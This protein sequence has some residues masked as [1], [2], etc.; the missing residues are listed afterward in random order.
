MALRD[1]LRKDIA[2]REHIEEESKKLI[3]RWKRELKNLPPEG[4][5][6]HHYP[7]PRAGIDFA[8]GRPTIRDLRLSGVTFVCRY[9]GGSTDKDLTPDEAE[10]YSGNEIDIVTIWESA[11][12]RAREGYDAG[13]SDA[14]AALRQLGKCRAPEHAVVYFAVDFD[15]SAGETDEYFRGAKD[16][17]GL[18][19]VG[20]YG[21][22]RVVSHLIANRIVRYGWQTYAWSGG[23]WSPHAQL[24]QVQNGV[25]LGGVAVDRDEA[26]AA[27]FGQWR[28]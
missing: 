14:R 12:Q 25:W 26:V 4:P 1:I 2:R 20:V 18:S 27:D 11:A 21:G 19:R 8:W 24:R 28:V 15:A 16:V 6:M 22:I 3:E 13:A 5:P 17:L 9:L 10:N 7:L 23:Q